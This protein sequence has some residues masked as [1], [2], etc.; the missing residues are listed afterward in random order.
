[1][2]KFVFLICLTFCLSLSIF[3]QNDIRKVDFKNFTYVAQACGDADDAPANITVKDGEYLKEI[4]DSEGFTDRKYFSV[5]G[6]AYGD[7]D[8]DNKDEAAIISL[9]NTGGTGNFTEAYIYKMVRGKPV[10]QATLIGGDRGDGGFRNIKIQNGLMIVESSQ[11]GEMGAACCPEFIQT[12]K[13][14]LTGTNLKEVGKPIRRKIFEEKRIN[15]DRGKS[16]TSFQLSITPEEEIKRYIVGAAK[17]QTLTVTTNSD[18]AKVTLFRG[19]AEVL[20]DEKSLVAKLNETGDFIFEIRNYT[21]KT[22]SFNVNVTI[23]YT[24]RTAGSMNSNI[25]YSQQKIDSIY[26]DLNADKC[27]TLSSNPDEGGQYRGECPGVGNYKLEVLEGD[28]RQT[29]NVVHKQSGDIWELDLWSKVSGGFSAVG[30]KAEWRV[31]KVNGKWK[32]IALITRFNA[33]EN[34]EDSSKITSYLVV[35]KFDGEFVCVTDVVKP[36]KKQN[37]KAR[38]LADVAA[39]KPCYQKK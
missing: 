27:K 19:D 39:S 18:D 4:K 36:M 16:G 13:Y 32:P 21:D 10:L 26:T 2:R 28:L 11:V 30:E 14:R 3:A 5:Y 24:D 12:D 15:F 29:I 7:L 34:P 31:K 37:E 8:S 6:L 25:S 35:T 33:S 17:G 38:K 23:K 9:C 20:E 1:M 22:L